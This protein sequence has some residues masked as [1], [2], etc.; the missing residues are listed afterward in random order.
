[1]KALTVLYIFFLLVNISGC[2]EET[3]NTEIDNTLNGTWFNKIE[4]NSTLQYSNEQVITEINNKVVITS[5]DRDSTVLTRSDNA[6]YS[7]NGA[8]YYLEIQDSQTLT[9]T[10]DIDG[11][12]YE[13]KKIYDTNYFDSGSLFLTFD[14]ATYVDADFDICAQQFTSSYTGFVPNTIIYPETVRITA[15]YQDS[16]ITITILFKE[17]INQTYNLVGLDDFLND[18]TNTSHIT[19]ESSKF[20]QQYNTGISTLR[21]SSGSIQVINSRAGNFPFHWHYLFRFWGADRN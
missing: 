21:V 17:V 9:Y 19:I 8:I 4:T 3:S 5:C 12:Q 1:M 14:S 11:A 7:E 13:I 16:F 20:A 6:L 10:G 15:P 18:G 2:S